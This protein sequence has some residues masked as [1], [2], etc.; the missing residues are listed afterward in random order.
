MPRIT[1]IV[2][3]YKVEAFIERCVRSL[4]EQTLDGVEYLFIDD[5]TPD[6]SVGIL[7]ELID[8]YH[9]RIVDK[10]WIVR[11]E[12]MPNN[13]GILTVRRHGM[14]MATGDYVIQIDSD[15]WI[16]DSMLSD[17]WH[18]AMEGDLDVVICD[19]KIVG[20]SGI[21]YLKGL[22][23]DSVNLFIKDMLMNKSPWTL[24]NKLFKRAI[25]ADNK[26][27]Y[28]FDGMNLGEDM[29]LVVEQMYYCRTIGYIDKAYYNYF[30][31]STSITHPQGEEDV[32]RHHFQWVENIRTLEAFF[33]MHNDDRWQKEID[34]QKY[35][36]KMGMLNRI[37]ISKYY[38]LWL[39]YF[40]E[41][42]YQLLFNP[43]VSC[44][45][46]AAYYK[47]HMKCLS[48]YVTN[49]FSPNNISLANDNI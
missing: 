36:G 32:I 33:C 48:K 21:R 23:F 2:P 31:N 49:L 47:N 43:Y 30:E 44:R 20:K 13:S 16:E 34:Y 46:K 14:K 19:I 7:K 12:Q 18:V 42:F 29:A 5:C 35:K 1:V 40:P 22:Y 10:D 17:M 11:I 45:G 26:I 9:Q 6:G 27:I 4:F 39:P 41:L 37:N 8:E 15:D 3:V 24:V 25:Y 38:K 28:P